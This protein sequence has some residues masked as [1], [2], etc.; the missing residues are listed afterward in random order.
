[1]S[2]KGES[3]LRAQVSAR[4]AGIGLAILPIGIGLLFAFGAMR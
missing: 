2:I 3:G 1:M 4:A